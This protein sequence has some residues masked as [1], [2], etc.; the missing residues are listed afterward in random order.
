MVQPGGHLYADVEGVALVYGPTNNTGYILVSCQGLSAY[1]V[2][3][4][5]P[6]YEFVMT[7]A[8]TAGVV[9]GVTNT[10][11]V[12]AVGTALGGLFPRGLVV[13]HDDVNEAPDRTAREE[14]A[15]KLVDL[16]SVLGAD[17]VRGLGLLRDVDHGWSPRRM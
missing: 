9:D 17:T 6:P 16:G 15:F 2:Y 3:Q 14:A 4:R 5:A 13:V 1:N 10:D 8:I 7:F 12:A 11:G